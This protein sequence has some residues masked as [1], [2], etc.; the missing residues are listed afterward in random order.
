M[1]DQ[2]KFVRNAIAKKDYVPGLCHFRICNKRI[3]GYNGE[4]AISTPIGIEY[5]IAPLAPHF[6][7][8]INA[9]EDDIT[10]KMKAGKLEVRSGRFK[11]NVP[12]IDID[13]VPVVIPTGKRIDLEFDL[14]ECFAK[15]LPF[16]GE[17][18]SKPWAC[19]VL[20]RGKSAFVTNNI[21]LIEHW[22]GIDLPTMNIPTAAIA[23]V[24]RYKTRPTHLLVNENRVAF[25]Y[26]DGSWISHT[27]SVLEWPSVE[28]VLNVETPNFKTFP[29]GFFTGIGKLI[30]FSDELQR[31][32]FFEDKL[33]T[34]KNM[35]EATTV[36][37][38]GVPSDGCFNLKI[39]HSLRNTATA[40]DFDKWPLPSPFLGEG[41]RGVLVGYRS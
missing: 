15:L 9:C 35:D 13:Q 20:I 21:I 19:G 26:E 24:V 40:I 4:L 33:I 31:F 1:I 41:L 16:V 30:Q 11:A 37:C 7:K 22:I 23:E 12:C 17:D 29:D 18:A 27:L 6:M 2:L 14:S 38:P 3:T 32:Y 34:S 28:R 10:L 39:V 25:C 8:V 5:D 36:D